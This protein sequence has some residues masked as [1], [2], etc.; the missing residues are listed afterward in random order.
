[1]NRF[2]V[3]C[4]ARA[5]IQQLEP[6]GLME[7]F[8]DKTRIFSFDDGR[9]V[10]TSNP[11]LLPREIQ[12]EQFAC[13]CGKG[14]TTKIDGT[15]MASV[16][17]TYQPL[18]FAK[19]SIACAAG[20]Y[21]GSTEQT[22]VDTCSNCVPF[23]AAHMCERETSDGRQGAVTAGRNASPQWQRS[24]PGIHSASTPKL[25]IFRTKVCVFIT[26]GPITKLFAGG[27]G[28][29]WRTCAM[30]LQDLLQ[31]CSRGGEEESGGHVL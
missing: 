12:A 31:S 21:S 9:G 8:D 25:F 17:G 5:R 6:S 13:A 15:C 14:H 22:S 24:S 3:G 11:T 20:T 30:L 26:A 19:V 10:T 2:C 18:E 16:A 4:S 7:V 27:G 28:G 23:I 29:E 1:M